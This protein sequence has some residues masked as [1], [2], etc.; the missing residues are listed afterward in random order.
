MRFSPHDW[1]VR[2]GDP[3]AVTVL[4]E[5]RI[6]VRR[7]NS[8]GRSY[9]LALMQP[10]DVAGLPSVC[11]PCVATFDLFALTSGWIATLAGAVVRQMAEQ[12]PV[13][14]MRLVDLAS[15]ESERA[16]RRLDATTFHDARTR[17]A[18][19][20]LENEGVLASPVPLVSRADL[21]GLVGI[22]REMLGQILRAFETA[23]V[24][25]RR[26]RRICIEDRHRLEREAAGDHGSSDATGMPRESRP[27]GAGRRS[28][29]RRGR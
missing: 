11:G 7:T 16:L 18:E 9:T 4:V 5:G 17:L 10:G 13:V 26:G 8:R 15:R 27:V 6:A 23:A 19:V 14:S 24:V 2:A 29:R 20:I 1:L 21:A 22:S 3:L 12:D 25:R 28:A